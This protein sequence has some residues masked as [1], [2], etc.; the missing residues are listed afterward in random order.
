MFEFF[1]FLGSKFNLLVFN[2]DPIYFGKI[3]NGNDSR[4]NDPLIGP[5]NRSNT[6][7][8]HKS[9]CFD[10]SY[11]F[12][13]IGARDNKDYDDTSFN[14]SIIVLGDSFPFG[15]GLNVDKTFFKII[16]K[17]LESEVINLSVS[18]TNPMH[19]LK[20]FEYFTKN[21]NY[22]EI[23]YFFLPQNDFSIEDITHNQ[24][25]IN[26]NYYQLFK[27][28]LSKFTY[29]F[30]TLATI[31]F[32]YFNKDKSYDNFSYNIK[33]KDLINETFIFIEEVMK[34]KNKKKTLIIIPTRKDFQS[35]NKSKN[36]KKLY[37]YKK[38]KEISYK[39]NFK[40]IDLYDVFKVDEQFKYYHKCDG[41][42][43]EYGVNIASQYFLKNR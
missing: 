33:D 34:V 31:K 13:N 3:Y 26:K 11:Q 16:D 8:R 42:W 30:N 40:I 19:Y 4:Y 6:S 24:N 12:N 20:R 9:N 35:I 21:K 39:H 22:S 23:I 5:W 28:K 36:Y 17:E 18:G 2:S 41:H 7:V 27:N 15:H 37:W 1:S 38:I 32:I 25:S 43:N 10:V 29:S 14:K